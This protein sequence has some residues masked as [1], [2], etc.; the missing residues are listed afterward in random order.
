M[1]L[2]ELLELQVGGAFLP[3][4]MPNTTRRRTHTSDTRLLHAVHL[5]ITDKWPDCGPSPK[6]KLKR[7]A[8]TT[9]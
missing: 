1:G 4:E 3:D 6:N 2:A 9:D 8:F 7:D 5:C